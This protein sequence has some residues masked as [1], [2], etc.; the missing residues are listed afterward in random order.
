MAE[1]K[2]AVMAALLGNGALAVMKGVAAASTGSAAMLAE[3]L[4]AEPRLASTDY[5][6]RIGVAARRLEQ[7][8]GDDAGSPFAIA[9][10]QTVPA[11]E[12]LAAEVERAYRGPLA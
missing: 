11:V 10:Q 2:T 1:S 7:A 3:T 4:E 12:E 9:M 5:L 6:D 8:L